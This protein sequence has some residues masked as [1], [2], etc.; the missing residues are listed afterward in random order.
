MFTVDEAI[1]NPPDLSGLIPENGA[2]LDIE[3]TGL[4]PRSAGL[5]LIGA[6]YKS[7]RGWR[8][9][10]WFADSQL[11][12]MELLAA[13]REF[14]RPYSSLI[15]FNGTTFDLPFLK[16]CA[17]HYHMELGLEE[18]ESLDLY[19]ALRPMGP[20]LGMSQMKQKCFE[21]RIG[22]FR[23][24]QYTGGELIKVYESYKKE[25]S[26]DARGLLLLH[27]HDDL[28]GML[29]V[30]SMLSY[31]KLL[32]QPFKLIQLREEGEKAVISLRA[33]GKFAAPSPAEAFYGDFSISVE[34]RDILIRVSMKNGAVRYFFPDYQ[35]YFYL[36]QE[37]QAIHRS[38][39]AYVDSHFRKK[40][41]FDTAYQWVKTELLVQD[42]KQMN[43]YVRRL[44]D[45]Y[46]FGK[47]LR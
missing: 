37:D 21:E 7:D 15:H 32:N 27:N 9:R 33:E 35:N 16:A 45:H 5:Y 30:A 26:E 44:F 4:S 46:I 12:E 28:R 20:F 24:D 10:Q 8:C 34:N 19:S 47:R 43:S 11:Q 31:E 3:T 40:A 42:Q 2:F 18:K 14:L 38:V 23:E 22:L 29:F 1:D 36:P 13:C 39:G 17:D 41:T 25:P 6:A